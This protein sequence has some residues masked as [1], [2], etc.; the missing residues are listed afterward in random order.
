VEVLSC[1]ETRG[2]RELLA[3][4]WRARQRELT[5]ANGARVGFLDL[6]GVAPIK[7]S[8]EWAKARAWLHREIGGERRVRR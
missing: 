3:E 4:F 8:R 6:V 7:V 1:Q 2:G 5:N